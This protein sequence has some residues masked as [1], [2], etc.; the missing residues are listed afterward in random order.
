MWK[1]K[2]T[3]DDFTAQIR[4][5]RNFNTHPVITWM[6]GGL[7]YQI[8]HHLFPAVPRS[9]LPMISPYVRELAKQSGEVYNQDS[10]RASYKEV[11]KS[12][13]VI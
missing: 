7:N 2:N 10:I 13:K 9:K 11:F 6:S 3:L 4:T 12:L 8:E 1:K 5:T